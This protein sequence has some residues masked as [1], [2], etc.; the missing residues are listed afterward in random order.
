MIYVVGYGKCLY[1]LNYNLNKTIS[2]MTRCWIKMEAFYSISIKK[3]CLE[4]NLMLHYI[5]TTCTI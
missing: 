2:N 1:Y 4:K 5:I 3:M